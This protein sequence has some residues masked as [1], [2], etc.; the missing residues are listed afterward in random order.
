M[1]KLTS[2]I[3]V[4]CHTLAADSLYSNFCSQDSSRGEHCCSILLTAFRPCYRALELAHDS[5]AMLVI[6]SSLMVYSAFRLS[7][8]AKAGSG[9]L[10]IL[11][12]GPTRADAIAD[13]KASCSLGA[14]GLLGCHAVL[15][16]CC[17]ES[18][19]RYYWPGTLG[20]FS[21]NWA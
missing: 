4:S 17:C 19:L 6:G 16:A 21:R 9:H 14:H 20:S 5:D 10:A 3:E 11:S 1:G 7:K 15:S 12:A 8:A 2:C 18:G 13:L